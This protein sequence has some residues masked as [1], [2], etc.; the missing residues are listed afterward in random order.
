[1]EEDTTPKQEETT[2]SGQ[3][4][5]PPQPEE[6]KKGVSKKALLTGILA[7]ILVGA[8]GWVGYQYREA[9]R[10]IDSLE[11]QI[12]TLDATI[13]ENAETEEAP[14][15]EADEAD[16]ADDSDVAPA[17]ACSSEASYTAEVGEFTI[18]LDEPYVIVR[19][20]DA[21]FEGGPATNLQIASCI[22]GETGVFDAPYQREAT[23]LAN[24]SATAADLRSSY[25]TSSGALTADGTVDIDGVTADRYTQDVLFSTTVLFFDN[26]GIGYQIE[27]VGAADVIDPLSDDLLDDWSFE[28]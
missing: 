15:D 12:A 5:P 26:D 18:M 28:S 19:N 17:A 13:A 20:L 11:Q 10:Q 8:L 14:A 6:N 1:M 27:F 4:S 3:T 24:P 2:E 16:T 23:I 21:G 9:T 22:E 7:V 25:E